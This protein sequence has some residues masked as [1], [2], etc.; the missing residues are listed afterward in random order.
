MADQEFELR[1]D[2]EFTY[3]DVID[4]VRG[5]IAWRVRIVLCTRSIH[6]M[7]LWRRQ[8]RLES[9]ALIVARATW[10]RHPLGIDTILRRCV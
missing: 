3:H 6:Y 8:E 1:L 10:S 7:E 9:I 2:L 5:I 4:P